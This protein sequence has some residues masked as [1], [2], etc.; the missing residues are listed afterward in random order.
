MIRKS[1]FIWNT[2][3]SI[4]CSLLS[5]VLLMI[6]TRM[7]GTT[8]A[9]M[10]SIAFATAFILNAIGDYGIRI[11]QVTDAKRKYSFGEYLFARMIVVAIMIAVGIIFV[12]IS[13]YELE[14]LILCI[15]L[16]LFKAIDNL[17]ES[18]QAEFQLQGRLDLGGKS[19]V[20]RNVIAMLAFFIVDLLTK[21]IIIASFSMLAINLIIFILYDLRWIKKFTTEKPKREKTAL[22]N[23]LKECTPLFGSTLLSMYLNNAVKYAID[24]VRK[25]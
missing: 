3:G 25:L 1:E 12:F 14:K 23:I 15:L 24:K 18:Y 21:N 16:I 11:Y 13:G 17:S 9:G 20:Y 4:I 6:C 5:A 22:R 2:I 7:N 10:F 19:V 8:I